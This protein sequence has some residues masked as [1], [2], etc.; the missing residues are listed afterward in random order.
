VRRWTGDLWTALLERYGTATRAAPAE[1]AD[2]DLGL[3]EIQDAAES[4]TGEL[5]ARHGAQP[6]EVLESRELVDMKHFLGRSQRFVKL[7]L[8]EGVTYRT[9]EHLTLL[10]RN[11]GSLV[12]RVADRFG[13]DLHRTLRLTARRRSRRAPSTCGT[14]SRSRCRT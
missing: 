9:G 7:R 5:A 2:T 13:L 3:Y 6:M 14:T 12:Q 4:V 8:P 10:P 1:E 11:R